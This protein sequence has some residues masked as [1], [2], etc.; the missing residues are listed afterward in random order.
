MMQMIPDFSDEEDAG[1]RHTVDGSSLYGEK[2]IRA[3]QKG[4]LHIK[5]DEAKK[6]VDGKPRKSAKSQHKKLF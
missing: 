6:W 4:R 1:P 3:D 5:L 2:L